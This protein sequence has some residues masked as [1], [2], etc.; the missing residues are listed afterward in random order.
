[1]GTTCGCDSKGRKRNKEKV[2]VQVISG[3][4]T[5]SADLGG[6]VHLRSSLQPTDRAPSHK[7]PASSARADRANFEFEFPKNYRSAE[8]DQELGSFVQSMSFIKENNV[9]NLS[10]DLYGEDLSKVR[11]T[12]LQELKANKDMSIKVTRQELLLLSADV[13]EV[14]AFLKKSNIDLKSLSPYPTATLNE[15]MNVS[16]LKRKIAARDQLRFGE[17]VYPEDLRLKYLKMVDCGPNG[18]APKREGEVGEESR[19]LNTTYEAGEY[20]EKEGQD[21]LLRSSVI[22]KSGLIAPPWDPDR[23]ELCIDT[24]NRSKNDVTEF[25]N[26]LVNLAAELKVP[27][28]PQGL[29]PG[30]PHQLSRAISNVGTANLSRPSGVLTQSGGALPEVM[31][32]L[33]PICDDLKF[34]NFQDKSYFAIM[35]SIINYDQVFETNL[36]KRLI[37][38]QKEGRAYPTQSGIHVVKLYVNGAKRAFVCQNLDIF[39]Y[40]TTRNEQYPL[41]LQTALRLLYPDLSKICPTV[42]LFRLCNWI[43][44]KMFV[45]DVGDVFTS[46]DK[47][48]ET[49]KAGNLILQW[50]E[51][52]TGRVRPVLDFVTPEKTFKRYIKTTSEAHNADQ[53][54][55]YLADWEEL[56]NGERIG[57]LY[58]NWNP[59][60]YLHRKT[61][62]AL[63]FGNQPYRG[64]FDTPNFKLQ[65]APQFL[66]TLHP[67]KDVCETRIVIEKHRSLLNIPYKIK[68]SLY[69]FN[70]SRI[71][72]PNGPLREVEVKESEEEL[73]S[74]ILIFD[75]NPNYENYVIVVE[76]NV[77]NEADLAL[78]REDHFEIITIS[79]YTFAE[80]DLIEMP[81]SVVEQMVASTPNVSFL[82]SPA[83]QKQTSPDQTELGLTPNAPYY[84]LQIYQRDTYEIRVDAEVG[85]LAEIAIMNYENMRRSLSRVQAPLHRSENVAG[86][87]SLMVN[88]EPGVYAVKITF[89]QSGEAVRNMIRHSVKTERFAS[90]MKRVNSMRPNVP[91]QITVLFLAFATKFAKNYEPRVKPPGSG[92][93]NQVQSA[94]N[95][96]PVKMRVEQITLQNQLPFKRVLKGSWSKQTNFG[97]AKA[98]IA[99]YQK[100]M[101]NPGFVLQPSADSEFRF[102][103]STQR[104]SNVSAF[105]Y[106]CVAV[107]EIK[108]DFSF[109]TILEDEDYI[110][111]SEFTTDVVMLR[112]NKFGYLVVCLTL[113][114]TFQAPFELEVSSEKELKSFYDTKSGIL[115][116]PFKKEVTG[117]I[118][119]MTGGH[120]V[121]P[122]F[123][124][125]S[126]FLLTF[127]ELR[128]ESLFFAELMTGPTTQNISLYLIPTSKQSLVELAEMD[129]NNFD[130]NAAF[131]NQ[132]NGLFRPITASRYLVVPSTLNVLTEALPFE[133][134]IQSTCRFEV[135]RVPPATFNDSYVITQDDRFGRETKFVLKQPDRVLIVVQPN[136]SDVKVQLAVTN[137]TLGKEIYQ[138]F[139]EVQEGFVFKTLDLQE[140]GHQYL[141]QVI[142]GRGVTSTIKIYG[143]KLGNLHIV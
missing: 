58:I 97:S 141:L 124:F 101:K 119:A 132:V 133:L 59:T 46:F 85:V 76:L 74:D 79:L 37:F 117:E 87:N 68:Y 49:F 13:P 80:F 63:Y 110:Q 125:N 57:N 3:D 14:L 64:G 116:F 94:Q 19:F 56:Y 44:E 137:L 93:D 51:L 33:K 35:A 52:S 103:L 71:V 69:S 128:K 104:N 95:G 17:P 73:L 72:L 20:L 134:K 91:E 122:S 9:N 11:K 61:M 78:I 22:N 98:K 108:D 99:C 1:M 105:P 88:L 10:F 47:L 29:T 89:T 26:I 8:E 67:H 23:F 83:T 113:E 81:Y 121:K 86:S 62:H 42:L 106:I 15:L 6:P 114:P 16:T 126:A 129:I 31:G 130:Y 143:S 12:Y 60:I 4:N 30:A 5:Q 77:E 131:L 43:P 102:R 138:S 32:E 48:R 139:S 38:P 18:R 109:N 40:L 84:K 50:E 54:T 36:I 7:G 34:A 21:L 24:E 127:E 2:R 45:K 70:K 100:F 92:F 112:P 65:R 96:A 123:L 75:E 82:S 118:K 28:N 41:V 55:F 115:Q 140:S 135:L 39:R 107:F 111:A 66:F 120:I 53:A 27:H 25:D 142:T 136:N 90:E